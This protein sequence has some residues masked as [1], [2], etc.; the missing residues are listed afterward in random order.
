MVPA[1]VTVLAEP[2]A[3]RQRQGRPPRARADRA[4]RGGSWQERWR[5]AWRRRVRSRRCWRRSGPRCSA[6]SGADW[7]GSA[8]RTTSSTLGGHSL[9]ATQVMSR[10]RDAFGVELPLRALFE[11]PTVAALAARIDGERRRGARAAFAHRCRCPRDREPAALVRPAAPLVPRPAGAGQPVLQHVRRRPPDRRARPGRPAREPSAR[12]SAATRR[13]APRSS[14]VE[15]RPRP[16]DRTAAGP[17]RLPLVDLAG[18]ADDAGGGSWRG[19]RRDEARRPFDLASGP[20]R[21]APPCSASPRGS[22]RCW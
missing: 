3:Q 6:A 15:R 20:A 13:C 9:L 11:A 16:G 14:P 7:R 8:P 17:R 10:V 12:S 22:T 4:G 1:A 21:S 5:V 18:L 19:C 2:A